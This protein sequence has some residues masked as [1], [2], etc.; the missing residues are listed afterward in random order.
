MS[1][2]TINNVNNP[3]A[4]RLKVTYTAGAGELTISKIESCRTDGY[5]TTSVGTNASV[6]YTFD[7]GTAQETSVSQSLRNVYFYKNSNYS[8]LDISS[9]TK[10]LEG[11]HTVT[12]T[13]SGTANSNINNSRFE[14][15]VDFGYKTP[16]MTINSATSTLESISLNCSFTGATPSQIEVYEATAGTLYTGS[17]LTPTITGLSPGQTYSIKVRGYANGQWGSYTSPIAVSTYSAALC[18][19][20]TPLTNESTNI[21]FKAINPSGSSTK[22]TIYGYNER[23]STTVL[24]YD[25]YSIS[26]PTTLQ[27]FTLSLSTAQKNS[28]N[29][30]SPNEKQIKLKI[31]VTTEGSI[32]YYTLK[33]STYTVINSDPTLSTVTYEDVNQT[34]FGITVNDQ[35]IIADHSEIMLTIPKMTV[36]NGATRGYYNIIKDNVI[37]ESIEDDGSNTYSATIGTIGYNGTLQVEAVDSRGYSII[38]NVNLTLLEYLDPVVTSFTASRLNDVGERVTV[39]ASGTYSR[40]ASTYNKNSIQNIK[41]RYREISISGTYGNWSAYQNLTSFTDNQDGTWEVNNVAINGDTTEGYNTE[42][43]YQ[44]EL[45][46]IDKLSSGNSTYNISTSKPTCWFD[47]SNKRLGI[48]KKPEKSL[49]V[50]GPADFNGD[51]NITG[52]YKINGTKLVDLIYPVGSIYISTQSTSPQTLFGGSWTQ[53]KD[54]FLLTAGD[55]YTAGSTGGEAT[56]VLTTNEMPSHNHGAGTNNSFTVY[57]GNDLSVPSGSAYYTRGQQS[58]TANAGGG[59][60]H[61]NMP[62]Y[63]VVYAWKRDS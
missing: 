37:V 46:V 11:L 52:N 56:H 1:V 20:L 34:T 54:T 28:L 45:V 21:K 36:R 31:S 43:S 39:R 7:R 38:Q 12:I 35:Q 57:N 55:T 61:N 50:D 10:E 32:D 23:T 51:V 16:T 60:A 42:K 41:Y 44:I 62:P 14:F 53:I 40:L 63:L 2:I 27:E 17:S 29:L 5:D 22:I 48:G 15:E 4:M 13:F 33:E 59:Q 24:L 18:T 49:D 9:S 3:K 30:A 6:I 58:N 19:E 25:D 8:T 47:R 26:I